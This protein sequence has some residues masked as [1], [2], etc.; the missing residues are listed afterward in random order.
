VDTESVILE[1]DPRNRRSLARLGVPPGRRYLARVEE[2]GVVIL[3]PAVVMTEAEA[4]L[5]ANPELVRRLEDAEANPER[6]VARPIR[7][8]KAQGA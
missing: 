1:T 2:D 6:R 5:H 3:E 4:R 8:A 7:R